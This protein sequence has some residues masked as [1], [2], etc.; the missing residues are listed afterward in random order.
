MN[1]HIRRRELRRLFFRRGETAS[2]VGNLVEDFTIKYG[3][4]TAVAVGIRLQLTWDEKRTLGIRTIACIDCTQEEVTAYYLERR[5]ERNRIRMRRQRL[6][7]RR[8]KGISPR[9]KQLASRLNGN[10]IHIRNLVESVG[11]HGAWGKKLKRDAMLLAVWRAGQELCRL[12]I[13]ELKIEAVPR[14]GR[15]TF[16]RWNP[17]T[18]FRREDFQQPRRE[19]IAR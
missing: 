14:G 2:E 3:E 15:A 19:R 11:F 13:A 16:L 18:T 5:R 8:T 12:G 10:W 7:N 4:A 9:A 1:R 17:A 6:R